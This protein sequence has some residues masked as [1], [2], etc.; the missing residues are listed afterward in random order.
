MGVTSGSPT[1]AGTIV[2]TYF[3]ERDDNIA[4]ASARRPEYF[5][6]GST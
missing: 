3:L 6:E 4:L 1:K 2:C 5:K